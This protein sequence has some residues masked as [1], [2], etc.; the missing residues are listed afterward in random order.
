MIKVKVT[1]EV[2]TSAK[3]ADGKKETELIKQLISE[4]IERLGIKQQQ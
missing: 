4:L 2:S 3:T 1:I